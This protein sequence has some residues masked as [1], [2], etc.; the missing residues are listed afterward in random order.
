LD[1]HGQQL[2]VRGR[3]RRRPLEARCAGKRL[4]QKGL[5]PLRHSGGN[6]AQDHKADLRRRVCGIVSTF[7]DGRLWYEVLDFEQGRTA[8]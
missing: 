4:L 8:S 1:L 3:L 7:L 2:F 6:A 5:T